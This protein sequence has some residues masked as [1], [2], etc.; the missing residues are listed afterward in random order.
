MDAA[1]TSLP[2]GLKLDRRIQDADFDPVR[3]QEA[4]RQF[5]ALLITQ[6]LRASRSTGGE[7]WLGT[8]EDQAASSAMEMAEEYFAHALASQGGLGLARMICEELSRAAQARQ[9]AVSSSPAGTSSCQGLAHGEG[10]CG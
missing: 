6:L 1:L 9:P 4:A 3:I 8:G 2:P 5:E 10:A 7:G